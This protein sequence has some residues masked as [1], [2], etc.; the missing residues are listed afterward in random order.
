MR[1]LSLLGLAVA[2][3]L[4]GPNGRPWI[5]QARGE[6]VLTGRWLGEMFD[7]AASVESAALVVLT[8]DAWQAVWWRSALLAG[9]SAGGIWWLTWQAVKQSG[10]C[11]A[12]AEQGV[13]LLFTVLF[14][15]KPELGEWFVLAWAIVLAPHLADLV[16]R[17]KV[18]HETVLVES[19]GSRTT[20]AMS[21]GRLPDFAL[22][23]AAGGWVR[24]LRLSV[25][26]WSHVVRR[27]AR[28]EEALMLDVG[29]S[30]PTS[31]RTAA[32]RRPA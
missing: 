22:A 30:R 12:S 29:R 28:D 23:D 15:W 31:H 8:D 26:R 25:V 24:T 32:T 27:L 1:W 17:W 10:R 9:G 19:G 13:L 16:E 2:A 3:T 14:W 18:A 5:E 4:L 6:F 21:G 11:F 7:Q 20:D